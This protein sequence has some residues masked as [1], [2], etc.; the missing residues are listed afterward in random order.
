MKSLYSALVVCL[1]TASLTAN[2]TAVSPVVISEFMASN[3]RGLADEDGANPDW[4]EIRNTSAAAV[5]LNDWSLTDN[6]GSLTK[7]RFPDTNINA[8]AYLVIFASGKNRRV[9]GKPLHTDFQLSSGGEYLALVLPDGVTIATQFA[10]A[11]PPQVPNVSY[12]FGLVTSN[13]T[14]ISTSATLR[15]RIPVNDNDGTNWTLPN[16]DENTWTAGTN[17]VGYGASVSGFVRTDVRAA[18]SNVNATAH[19]RIP[20]VVSNAMDFSLFSLRMRYNDGFAAFING[21]PVTFANTPGALAFNSAAP[22]NHSAGAVE[23]FRFGVDTNVVVSGTNILAIQGLNAAATNNDFLILGELVATTVVAEGANPIYFTAPTP[24]AEN[25][26]GV[27]T[28]GPVITEVGHTP[29]VPLDDQDVIV[30]ARVAQSFVNAF[31]T[32]V[33]LGYRIMF[34]AE[35]PVQMLDDGLHGDGAAGDG[36]FG[37]TIPASA[38]TNGQMIRYVV[39][40]SDSLGNASRWPLFYNP[41][42]SPEYLGTIVN[43]TNLTSKLPIMHLFA[44]TGVLGA[45]PTTTQTGADSEGGGRVSFFYDG[46]FY[47]N[48]T[49]QLR[50]N[51]TATYAKKSH[52]VEFNSE[53]TFRHPGASVRV[54]KT[55]FIADYPDPSYMRQRLAMWLC[56]QIGS[57]AP[58]YYPVRLQLN[59]AFY[60]LANHNE[61]NGDDLAGHLG[62]DQNG[63][64]YKAAGQVTPGQASTGGFEKLN[65]R[66]GNNADY[67]AFATAIGETQTL[68]ARRTNI[69]DQMDVPNIINY[70]VAARWA[71]ENDDIWAN[72]TIHRDTFGTKEWRIIPFDLNLSWGAIYAE[73]TADLY[74][75]IQS[76]NDTHKGHPLYGSSQALALSGPGGGYNRIYDAIFQVPQTREMYLRRLRTLMDTYVKPPG[77]PSNELVLEPMILQ[78]R[79]DLAEEALR[80]RTFWSWPSG[81]SGQNSFPSPPNPAALEFTNA[82][83]GLLNEFIARRRAHFYVKHSITSATAAFPVGITKTNNAGIPISQPAASAVSIA[84]IEFNPATSNQLEEYICVTNPQPYAVDISSWKLGGGV[85]FTF[86][87]GTVLPGNSVLYVSPD[88]N[89]FRARATAPRAGM[90]LFVQGP[91]QGQLSARGESLTITDTYGRQVSSNSYVGN[92]SL[93]QQNLRITEIMY[94]PSPLAGN[95]NDAQE[96]EYIEIKNISGSATVSLNGV[97]FINGVEFNFAGSAITSLLPGARVLVVR[98]TAAFTARYGGGLPVAGPFTNTLDN[99]GERIQ[100]VDNFNEEILDFSYNNSWYPI[101][102]GFGF[103]LVVVNENAEPDLWDSKTNWRPSGV[104]G[105]GPGVVDPPTPEFGMILVN[106]LLSHTD[107]PLRDQVELFNASTTNVNIG[108]WFLSD[109]FR[110]PKKFRFTNGTIIP[111]GGYLVIDETQFSNAPPA[112]IAFAFS[113]KGD[114]AWLFSGDANTNLTGYVSGESYGAAASGVSF[115][116]Y[117]NSQGKVHFVAQSANTFNAANAAPAVGPVVFSEIHYHPLDL[118]GGVDDSTNEFIEVRNITGSPVPLFHAVVPTNTWH[119]RG[120][121]DYVFP[122][123][124]TLAAGESLLLVNFS[125]ANAAALAAFQARFGVPPAVTVLGPYQGKLNNDFDDLKLERPDSPDAGEVPYILV[126]RVKYKD[127]DGW[128]AA[129]DGTGASLQRINV[130]GYGNDPINWVAA[131]PSAGTNQAV[132]SAPSITSQPASQNSLAGQ[133]VMFS[134][135]ASPTG[136]L[137]YQWLYKGATIHDATNSIL[138]LN[139]LAFAQSGTYSVIVFNG[140]GSVQSS[141]AVLNVLIPASITQQPADVDVRI[142]P[143]NNSDVAPTTNATFTVNVASANPP[144]NYQW[145]VNGTNITATNL[146]GLNAATLLVSNVVMDN[147]GAYS[148]QIT[149]GNGSLSSASATLYPLVRPLVW[150]GPPNPLIVPAA[151]P[152]PVSVVLSNGWPPPFGYQWRSNALAISTPVSNSKTNFFVIPSAFIATNAINA[153]FRVIVSNRAVPTFQVAQSATFTITTLLDTDR[154]GIADSV[155]TAL[156]LNPNNAADALL[157][158]DGDGLSN[159]AEYQAGTNPNDSNSFLRVSLA[160]ANNMANVIVAAVS[161]RTYTVQYSDVLPASWNKLA[162]LIARATNRVEVLKDPNWTTNRFYRI[163]LP[164]Q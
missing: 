78:W 27:T 108:G 129:A 38:S 103:S 45:G 152:V 88:V 154:D 17:G 77:T 14:L 140:V 70:A 39:R 43:P 1:L 160:A 26:G 138:T 64:Y 36:V 22:T 118:P 13:V 74:T 151:Q 159:L 73:G 32:N 122:T 54:R 47:D 115:G 148:C 132:G 130:A 99:A 25:S 150:F 106:E 146:F 62:Y 136:P 162:D 86:K 82:V 147:F 158:L 143:D 104:L 149:D 119:L 3:T 69:F 79:D 135:T 120:G 92:P 15:V 84:G 58:F 33:T 44:N 93:A 80:D 105:G 101:T 94:N 123:N 112:T 114:E 50:G 163:A 121:V 125:P 117:T 31:V 71:H 98:N 61:V 28:P 72:M 46:E 109:D 157:D 97:R 155:E 124:L 6:P 16:Y 144:I 139:S 48:I 41:A 55:S 83:N 128:P 30:T 107:A 81:P 60:Q 85:S 42:G 8:G 91:Y 5:N 131:T 2:A 57:P 161:N 20:F 75:G 89:A 51:T 23:E 96:F 110:T 24:G 134:V 126:D 37:A 145:R 87:P 111:A 40:A 141:N 34:N 164:A 66:D 153:T 127:G 137:R 4:I 113:G 29:N 9:P 63:A 59:G 95:T 90:G 65:P 12:G 18:M 76:T 67:A 53:H 116:R 11:F 100:L 10:P 56:N 49:M 142:R 35:V 133:T 156:G 52:R 68:A 102:D 19:I 7:W 21:V